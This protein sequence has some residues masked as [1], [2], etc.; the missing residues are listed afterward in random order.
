MPRLVKTP[1]EIARIAAAGKILAAVMR[2]VAGM[3]RP[4]VSLSFLDDAAY[5]LIAEAGA[6]PA[7]LGYRPHGSGRAYPASICA[8][9]NE[10]VV[11]GIPS[12]R[13]LRNGDVLKLDF[14]LKR[15]GFFVDAA[16][17]VGVGEISADAARLIKITKEALGLAIKEC[18]SGKTLGDIGFVI[19][20][21]ARKNGFQIV[22]ELTGHGVGLELHEEPVVLNY[23]KRGEGLRLEEGMVLAIEPMISMGSGEI[24][25]TEDD[26]YA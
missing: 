7:F 23:G 14:G 20:S 8:S 18:R 13:V 12:G 16:L 4:G 1:P 26:A 15:G 17:T 3:V 5:R 22:R 19:D 2:E 24:I 10:V 6:K 21:H 11:H 25:Q 9:L